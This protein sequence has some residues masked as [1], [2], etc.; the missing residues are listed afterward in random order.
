[1][2]INIRVKEWTKNIPSTKIVQ[3]L[4]VYIRYNRAIINLIP[5]GIEYAIIKP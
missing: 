4:T 1:M 2:N 5:K 3:I